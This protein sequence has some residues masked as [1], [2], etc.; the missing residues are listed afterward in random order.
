MVTAQSG[1]VIQLPVSQLLFNPCFNSE[2]EGKV[3]L[4]LKQAMEFYRVVKGFH[5]V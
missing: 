2:N 3:K 5:I 4:S 1:T